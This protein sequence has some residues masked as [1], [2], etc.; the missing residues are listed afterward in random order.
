MEYVR[1]ISREKKSLIGFFKYTNKDRKDVILK[2]DSEKLEEKLHKTFNYE[3][4]FIKFAENID[5][6][7]R[8]K[9][10]KDEISSIYLSI[11]GML[12]YINKYIELEDKENIDYYNDLGLYL[13]ELNN[14]YL[15]LYGENSVEYDIFGNGKNFKT[16]RYLGE[17]SFREEDREIFRE[18]RF[19]KNMNVEEFLNI[20][21]I[22]SKKIESA[23]DKITTDMEMDIYKIR[24][25]E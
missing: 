3:L 7:I 23:I 19:K 20:I 1:E 24:K 8:K 12:K 2:P 11:N 13:K 25:L 15:K 16:V 5:K 17:K 18:M 4:D 9:L 6:D 21:N 22:Y 14:K 10:D